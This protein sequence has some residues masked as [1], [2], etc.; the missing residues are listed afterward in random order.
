[1]EEL[2][3]IGY[4]LLRKY[5]K[6]EILFFYDKGQNS[7]IKVNLY[8]GNYKKYNKKNKKPIAFIYDELDALCQLTERS[9]K[10]DFDIEKLK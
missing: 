1:M 2:K 9:L 3:N 8:W 4:I 10:S 6:K 7:I 5:P